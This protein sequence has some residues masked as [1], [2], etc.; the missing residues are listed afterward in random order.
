MKSY[1][2]IYNGLNRAGFGSLIQ[3]QLILNHY[4]AQTN[5]SIFFPGFKNLDHWQN[6][7]K[8]QE[9]FCKEL[10]MFFTDKISNS[11]ES[12]SKYINHLF[13][14]KFWAEFN[15]NNIIKYNRIKYHGIFN[16]KGNNGFTVAIHYRALLTTDRG[17]NSESQRFS[18]K[19]F[20]ENA[21]KYCLENYNQKI[22]FN[23]FCVNKDET[24]KYLS[25]KF[26]VNVLDNSD[27]KL[28]FE[29]LI[30]SDILIASKSS[31]SW[32]AHLYGINK[33]VIAQT[34]W[35]PW[36]KNTILINDRGNQVKSFLNY[37]PFY[38]KIKSLKYLFLK[39][40]RTDIF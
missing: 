10:N 32:S 37:K 1:H 17:I 22:Q 14:V 39:Y 25:D 15:L 30:S 34:F 3:A 38:R 27:L 11:D 19:E 2:T 9:I 6:S 28:T 5:K 16:K 4:V 7:S 35:H 13:L 23:L 12:E 33:L 20:Y 24:T 40:R 36:S 21:I 26:D 18:S 29:N 8:T 31:L